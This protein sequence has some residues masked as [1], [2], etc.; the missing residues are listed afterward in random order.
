MTAATAQEMQ[1]QQQAAQQQAITRSAPDADA[2]EN[3]QTEAAAPV[4]LTHAE[5][6]YL[7]SLCLTTDSGGN[8]PGANGEA[9]LGKLANAWRRHYRMA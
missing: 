4:R 7:M 9:L 5:V 1:E 2:I 8:A 6:E 3:R